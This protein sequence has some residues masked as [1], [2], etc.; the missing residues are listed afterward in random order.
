MD[1]NITPE[2]C[3]NDLAAHGGARVTSHV[4]PALPEVH[5]VATDVA[6]FARCNCPLIHNAVSG[7]SLGLALNSSWRWSSDTRVGI[8]HR[9]CLI[10][11]LR[12]VCLLKLVFEGEPEALDQ[13]AVAN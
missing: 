8:A 11:P 6:H 9:V 13:L 10:K 4:P 5:D 7:T 12:R 2:T 3:V 1:Y